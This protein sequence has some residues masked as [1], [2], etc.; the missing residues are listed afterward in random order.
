MTSDGDELI[1]F[2]GVLNDFGFG[3]GSC[4]GSGFGLGFGS[5]F[6][7]GFGFGLGSCFGDGLGLSSCFGDGFGLGCDG[8]LELIWT[9]F[10]FCVVAFNGVELFSGTSTTTFLIGFSSSSSLETNSSSSTGGDKECADSS[11]SSSTMGTFFG[12]GILMS[13]VC[14]LGCVKDGSE[15]VFVGIGCGGT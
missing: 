3:S 10:G 1:P 5:C 4:F 2:E 9:S 12:T 15:I 7:S 8:V 13:I 11:D 14:D 6:G